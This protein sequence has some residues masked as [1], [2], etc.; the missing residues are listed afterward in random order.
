MPIISSFGIG[1]L[2]PK[3]GVVVVQD[4]LRRR[5]REF[6]FLFLSPEVAH[7]RIG[8][9]S[10]SPETHLKSPTKNATRYV[11]IFGVVANATVCN[12]APAGLSAIMFVFE[13]TVSPASTV[14]EI[15]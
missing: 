14:N 7:A 2:I 15:S 5:H 11:D 13:M 10:A 4:V 1:Y 8:V 6:A 3:V 12:P 9:P